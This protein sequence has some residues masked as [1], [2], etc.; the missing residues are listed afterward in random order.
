VYFPLDRIWCTWLAT[1]L[2]ATLLLLT[3]HLSESGKVSTWLGY[4]LLWGVTGLTE[5]ST[6][7]VLV[8]LGCWACY[9]LHGR[10][11][12]WFKGAVVS[13]LAFVL[14]VTPWFVRNYRVFHHFVPIRDGFGLSL[15]LGTK[16]DVESVHWATYHVG[17]GPWSSNSEWDEFKRNGEWAYMQRE[18]RLAFESIRKNPGWFAWRSLRRVVFL[19]TGYWSFDSSYLADEPLDIPNI[20]VCTATTVLALLGLRKLFQRDRALGWL[21]GMTIFIFP[22]IYYTT[23]PEDYY[24]RP[25]DTLLVLLAIGYFAMRKDNALSADRS[26]E[27]VPAAV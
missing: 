21:F 25:I 14:V 18:Q 23:S 16:P 22:L 2:L 20:P 26:S 7:A 8:R 3:I 17:V 19:W 6:L 12:R 5:P 11:Q 13:A 10:Q 1:L 27:L 15:I 4:G 9:R 24:R